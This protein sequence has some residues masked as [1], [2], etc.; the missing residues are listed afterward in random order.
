MTAAPS[1]VVLGAGR[2]GVAAAYDMVRFGQA[3]RIALSDGDL[4]Q[5]RAGV[6][7]LKKLLAADLS[8]RKTRLL[9]VRVDG[10]RRSALKKLLAG[11][12]AVLST[13]PY[14][15]NPVAA[16]AAVAAKTPYADLGGY[17]ETTQK[18]LKLDAKAKRAGVALIPDCGVSPGLCNSLA[19]CGIQRLDAA[20]EVRMYCGGLPQV[21]RPPLG[22]KVVFSLEGLLGN[23]FGKA[24]VLK[25]GRVEVAPPLSAQEELDFGPP[26]GK[27]EAA[28]TG[29]AT[30]TCPW[31][32]AGRI[33]AYEYKTLRYPGHFDKIR[34]LND[35]GL[36]DTEPVNVDGCRL[37]PRKVFVALAG[38]RL[39]FPDDRDLLVQRVIVRGRKD[40]RKTEIVYDLLDRFDPATG[41]TAMQ[42]TTGFSAAVV[43]AALA[44]GQVREKGVVPLEKALPGRFVL[45]ETRKRG[46]MVKETVRAVGPDML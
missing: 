35:L 22:Y 40:G 37:V 43:T 19:A 9:A 21:P 4:P 45:E 5:A 1:Y 12:S 17:F 46:I 36:L 24:Y 18:I 20:E 16:E 3:A 8:R 32:Y 42:R 26:L 38:P 29:G 34:T 2:Q 13:L 44:L 33:R 14:D 31:T 30:S 10:R 25:N 6:A 15:L 41:F 27:L 39:R 23:Y 11:Q 7:R 28:V